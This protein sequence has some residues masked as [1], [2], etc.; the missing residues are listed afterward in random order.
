M[1]GQRLMPGFVLQVDAKAWYWP[2]GRVLYVPYG[3]IIVLK[4]IIRLKRMCNIRAKIARGSA[5]IV[6]CIS[7]L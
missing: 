2:A 1:V 5:G 3:F 6:F 4:I 7:L